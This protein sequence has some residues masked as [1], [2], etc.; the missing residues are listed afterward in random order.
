[1]KRARP[2]APTV[3]GELLV[4][5]PFDAWAALA[6]ANADSAASWTFGVAGMDARDVRALARAEALAAATGFCARLGIPTR[7]VEG[8]PGLIVMTGHQPEL[9]HPGVWAKDFLL[10]RL[11]DE[12]GA[13]AIDVVVDSDGF[14]SVGMR[15]PCMGP[16]P[17]SCRADLAVGGKEGCYGCA[18]VPTDDAIREFERAGGDALATLPVAAPLHNFERFCTEIR[19]AAPGTRNLAELV[20]LARRRYEGSAGTDY[21]ELPITLLAASRAFTRFVAHIALDARAFAEAYNSALAG[22]RE[23]TGTRSAAQPFPDLAIG[24]DDVE[25][26]FWLVG[27]D[28]RTVWAR[29]TGGAA[30]VADGAVL[31]ELGSD[32]PTASERLCA[33]GVALAPKALALTLFVRMFV[34]DLFIHGVGGGRYDQVTDDVIRRYFGVEPPSFAVAS[35]TVMLP[36]GVPV[37]SDTEIE[38]AAMALNR[39]EHNPDQML[40]DARFDSGEDAARAEALVSEKRELVARIAGADADKKAVG[41]RIRD[42]NSSLAALLAPVKRQLVERVARLERSRD[43]RDVLTD[44]T[45]PFCLWDPA[46]IRE[47][48]DSAVETRAAH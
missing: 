26:P 34:A 14:D 21:L 1:M 20:T 11:A 42:V 41:A 2:T 16:E 30:L 15:I 3:D 18:P 23:R 5:P 17:L 28:R 40:A 32:A 7:P 4:E 27:P 13:A 48:V 31:C 47:T 45:Y 36:L 25:L 33:S 38:D 35:L 46:E 44:R 22:Y 8:E 43:A 19:S 24:A 29:T 6:R 37:V 9:Y 10:Q 39:L 12:I